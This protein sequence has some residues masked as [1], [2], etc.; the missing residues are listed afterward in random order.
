MA[1]RFVDG[2]KPG[3]ITKALEI[4]LGEKKWFWPSGILCRNPDKVL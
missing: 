1:L 3:V 4:K 2:S